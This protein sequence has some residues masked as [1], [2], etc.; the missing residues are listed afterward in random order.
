MSL[1]VCVYPDTKERA[2]ADWIDTLE[3]AWILATV[4]SERQVFGTVAGASRRRHI[5]KVEVLHDHRID[6]HYDGDLEGEVAGTLALT[7]D[8]AGD[9]LKTNPAK[10]MWIPKDGPVERVW[11][12]WVP[13]EGGV[14][15]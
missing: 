11:T 2:N 5:A 1:I 3:L 6:F 10:A 13:A 8:G 4:S 14:P 7:W 9:V 15:F 12:A